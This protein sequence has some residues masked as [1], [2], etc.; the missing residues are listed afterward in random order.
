MKSWYDK[1]ILPTISFF[2]DKIKTQLDRLKTIF[3]NI[4]GDIMKLG[5]PLKTWFTGD[6]TNFIKTGAETIG[7]ILSGLFDSFNTVFSDIWNLAIYPIID[8]ITNV[9]LPFYTQVGTQILKSLGILFNNIKLIFDTL[10]SG[11]IAPAM[12]FI[13][14]AWGQMWDTVYSVWKERG[15]AISNGVNGLINSIGDIFMSYWDNYLKPLFNWIGDTI[16]WL[17][18]D[19]LKPLWDNLVN[20]VASLIEMILTVWNNFLGPLVSWIV[21]VLGPVIS[22]VFGTIGAVIGS[23]IAFIVDIISGFIR[24]LQGVLDFI[25]G[26]FSGDWEKAWQGIVDIFGGIF[27]MLWGLVKF[28]IN[29]IIDGLNFLWGAIYSVVSGIVNGI[30]GI[31]GAIG[32]VFGQDWHFS[33]PAEPPLIPKLA[34]GTVVPP[35]REF[36][37]VLGDNKRE[38]EIVSPLSTM[39]QAMLEA[40]AE[41]G[42]N[43]N[44]AVI[45]LN[46]TAKVDG[47]TLFNVVERVKANKGQTI[48][49]GGG[50]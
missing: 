3:G 2:G 25:T 8:K 11:A 4:F 19:H 29:L 9:L 45:N 18:D 5:E 23:V 47:E 30:G 15:D 38:P 10:W 24:V 22:T 32:D 20:F 37:A 31:A 40:L 13:V 7:I 26:I 41:A 17:W 39:K 34:S 1:N 42:A 49:I 33:M 6:F 48:S 36:L 14:T 46:V 27:D 35:N 50:W 43:L 21:T 16:T 44:D 12:G 28:P